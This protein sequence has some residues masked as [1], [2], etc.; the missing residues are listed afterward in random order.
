MTR[1]GLI[2]RKT[3]Q[4]TNQPTNQDT[5]WRVLLNEEME[6]M[7]STDTDDLAGMFEGLISS[8]RLLEFFSR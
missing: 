7:Y 5:R 6:L 1:K 4:P 2:R 3:Q 8:K